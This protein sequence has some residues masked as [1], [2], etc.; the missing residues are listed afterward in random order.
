[1]EYDC[2]LS[3]MRISRRMPRT[4]IVRPD[5]NTSTS[6]GEMPASSYFSSQPCPFVGID[7]GLPERSLKGARRGSE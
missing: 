1:M 3:S 6:C 2:W 4:E 5:S 7:R